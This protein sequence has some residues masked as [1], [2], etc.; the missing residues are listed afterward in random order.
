[1]M[2]AGSSALWLV[3]LL[4]GGDLG[5]TPS[6]VCDLRQV[7]AKRRPSWTGAECKQV[8]RAC[9]ETKRPRRMLAMMILESGMWEKAE[10]TV[11]PTVRD[12]GLMQVRCV[13]GDDGICKNGLLAGYSPEDLQDVNT[14]LQV[15]LTIMAE[16]ER[17]YGKAWVERYGGC[18]RKRP[19]SYAR[20]VRIM[21]EALAGRAPVLH[22][23]DKRKELYQLVYEFT[24]SRK[25]RKSHDSF[26]TSATPRK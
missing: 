4:L 16:K 6:F 9:A 23:G 17:L 18:T 5:I 8:A 7:V 19:C 22:R 20:K 26:L 11:S 14:N 2:V 1:M 13:L 12:E 3:V 10:V 25:C 24:K 15:A 21:E